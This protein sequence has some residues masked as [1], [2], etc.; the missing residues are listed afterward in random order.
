MIIINKINA[1][2]SHHKLKLVKDLESHINSINSLIELIINQNLE[3]KDSIYQTVNM[4]FD[5][6]IYRLMNFIGPLFRVEFFTFEEV[7]N[8]II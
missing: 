2:I 4:A 1:I 8:I 7:N 5:K 3:N 6:K